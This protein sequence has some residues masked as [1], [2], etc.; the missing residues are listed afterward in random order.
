MGKNYSNTLFYCFPTTLTLNFS[1]VLFFDDPLTCHLERRR[2]KLVELLYI[3]R[4]SFAAPCWIHLI[5]YRFQVS[6]L[7]RFFFKFFM[8]PWPDWL[9]NCC[10]SFSITQY[11][12]V[13]K[14]YRVVFFYRKTLDTKYWRFLFKI[15]I[16]KQYTQQ[17]N[18]FG[19]LWMMIEL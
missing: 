16:L 14:L 4:H 8:T 17:V 1:F 2:E 3:W 13:L 19:S 15:Y 5:I 9:E 10:P 18:D 7:F 11:M 6:F 12:S